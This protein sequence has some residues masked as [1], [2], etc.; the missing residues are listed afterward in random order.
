VDFQ[1]VYVSISEPKWRKEVWLMT[2]MD[3]EPHH[4]NDPHPW[5]YVR[6]K[7][8]KVDGIVKCKNCGLISWEDAVSLS[9]IIGDEE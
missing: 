4:T 8:A 9:D 2:G 1:I 7:N 3:H 6:L 5:R